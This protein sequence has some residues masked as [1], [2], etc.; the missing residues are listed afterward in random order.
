MYCE[1]TYCEV[2]NCEL[3][4]KYM[5]LT[6]PDSWGRYLTASTLNMFMSKEVIN[7][8]RLDTELERV[9]ISVA[10]FQ[11]LTVLFW[12]LRPL[13]LPLAVHLELLFKVSASSGELRL[14]Q[15]LAH[16][17]SVF[18]FIPIPGVV[19]VLSI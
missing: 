3:L 17:A 1:L 8:T 6:Y 7:I 19:Q 5:V 4:N 14:S 13:H 12:R 10:N 9:L 11:P 15:T 18:S 16:T 2:L